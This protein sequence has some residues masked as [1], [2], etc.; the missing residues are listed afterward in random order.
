MTRRVWLRHLT[1]GIPLAAFLHSALQFAHAYSRTVDNDWGFFPVHWAAGMLFGSL[2]LA[3]AF[4]SQAYISVWLSR[5]GF[6]KA[7][8]I[9]AGGLTQA[10]LAGLWARFV[11][12]EPS[13]PGNFSLTLP[14]IG[15]G[16][17]AGGAVAA[18]AAPRSAGQPESHRKAAADKE[19]VF[20]YGSLRAFMNLAAM[21]CLGSGVVLAFLLR[22]E[23]RASAIAFGACAAVSL[24]CWWGAYLMGAEVSVS[25][26]YMAW[27][28]G[29][30]E[31]VIPWLRITE[32]RST[33]SRL[34]IRSEE[35]KIVVDKQ[36]DDY[37]S[38]Y[39]LVRKYAPP[40]AWETL[41]LPLRRRASLL[42]P[43]ILCTVGSVWVAF[44]LWIVDYSPPADNI[45]L[46]IVIFMTSL[47]GC[48]VPSGL[49]MATFRCEFDFHEIRVG[50][51]FRRKTYEVANL[52][53]M[54]LTTVETS[55]VV[56][57]HPGAIVP[58]LTAQQIEFRFRDG[59]E[60]QLA[61]P[62][63]S[64]DPEALYHLLRQYYT[65]SEANVSQ[66]S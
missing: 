12:I 51:L 22:E 8:Q 5:R 33:M 55:E 13:L 48:P 47:G 65:P 64:V 34:L 14:M 3:P 63:I 30:R 40:Y 53:E 39:E 28:R 56:Q 61:A 6:G 18:F 59:T 35:S 32:I 29:R 1:L 58:P 43:G 16:F 21:I 24:F 20:G 46:A 62:K 41:S 2:I 11:G 52:V 36:L 44:M 42:V 60:L 10:T 17:L 26:T 23:I 15:A 25:E 45:D 66:K 49:Y 7:A 31:V 57:R 27:S 9:L 50:T 4:T 38:C 37:A 54:R 19:R